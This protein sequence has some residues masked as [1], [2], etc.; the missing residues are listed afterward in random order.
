MACF[1]AGY[2]TAT[3]TC[4]AK[5]GHVNSILAIWE[6]P[7]LK[8]HEPLCFSYEFLGSPLIGCVGMVLSISEI[9]VWYARAKAEHSQF[10]VEFL[11]GQVLIGTGVFVTGSGG[12]C[13]VGV[14]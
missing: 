4:S 1:A 9:N 3:R 11:S 2:R 5:I 12:G 7:Q 8:T 6:L 13:I 10:I 14:G